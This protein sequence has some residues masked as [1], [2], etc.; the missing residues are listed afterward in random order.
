MIPNRSRARR[1]LALALV[2]MAV[3]GVAVRA[4]RQDRPARLAT[5]GELEKAIAA[6]RETARTKP[7]DAA[8]ATGLARLLMM[9]GNFEE[10]EKALRGALAADP[11]NVPAI[12][13]L[14]RIDRMKYRFEESRAELAGAAALAPRDEDVR[15]LEAALA[16]DRM[17][18]AAAEAIYKDLAAV[19]PAP[20]A[21]LCGLAEVAYWE[22]RYDDALA[23]IGR[24]LAAD[25]GFGRAYL[26]KSLIHRIRQENDQWKT[27]GRKAVELG[28]FDDEAR[29]NL[30]NILARGE[31]KMNEGYAEA[32]IA[33][34]INPLCYQAHNYIGNGWTPVAYGEDKPGGPP[35]AASRIAALLSEGGAALIS[36]DL[37]RADR[38]F[39]EVLGLSGNNLRGMIGKGTAAYH[40]GRFAESF[41]WFGAALAVNP[42]YALA[43]YGLA[44]SLLRLKDAVNVKL[45]GIERSFAAK[46]APEPPGLGDVFINYASLDP[47]LR[48]IIRISVRPLRAFLP[49]DRDK[50]A[51]FFITPF[52][53]LQSEAPGM[54]GIRGQR[55]FDGRLWDD[56]KGLGG[57]HALS[58]EDWE[59][60]VKRLRFNVIAHEFTHQVHGFLPKDLRDEIRRLFDKAKKE[61]LTLD[62]YADFNEFEYFATG[63]EAYVSEG[64]LA[65]QKIAYGH[66]RAEL[67][68]RDPDLYRFIERLDGQDRL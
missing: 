56:V 28:P 11:R 31:Q 66:T 38:L 45:A 22:N 30:F 32:K 1:S 67:R 6:A 68:T 61:R 57:P 14:A 59:R 23:F 17:D 35:E 50:A 13:L 48:K 46:D 25:P 26:F 49:L 58:G 10:A 21:A 39:D 9:D 43:H 44:Q 18:F 41:K 51:T 27:A 16:V 2:V 19:G 37:D 33:L 20:A 60:D 55:T 47:D 24:C 15:L 36:R 7:R 62:F 29:A 63:V 3:S 52:H 5:F 54:A 42:D 64:K 40:R 12:V 4:F 65:D 34:R 8:A 53:M